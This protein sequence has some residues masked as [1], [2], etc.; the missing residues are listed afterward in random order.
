MTQ[1]LIFTPNTKSYHQAGY[2]STPC[3]IADPLCEGRR[4]GRRIGLDFGKGL[5]EEFGEELGE[6]VG[7]EFDKE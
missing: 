1:I 6:E 2:N 7:E 3:S 5:C 4:I